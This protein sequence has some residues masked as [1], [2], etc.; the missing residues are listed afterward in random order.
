MILFDQIPYARKATK[1]TELFLKGLRGL[2]LGQ[3][4]VV[5]MMRLNY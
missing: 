4:T 5:G 1:E 2:L 3:E